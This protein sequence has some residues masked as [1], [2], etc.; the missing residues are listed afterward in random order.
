MTGAL[1]LVGGVVG[2]SVGYAS[3]ASPKGAVAA[4][5][6]SEAEIFQV[7][8]GGPSTQFPAVGV[9]VHVGDT[10]GA[11]YNDETAVNNVPPLVPS[12][13]IDGTSV[14][15]VQ[16]A[17]S[18]A[19][20]AALDA[21]G[22]GLQKFVTKLSY[23]V[24]TNTLPGT[25]TAVM[26]AW[27][28]DQNKPGGDCGTAQW[29]YTVQNKPQLDLTVTKTNDA[30]KDGAFTDT[31]TAKTVGQAVDFKV[32]IANPNQVGVVIDSIKDNWPGMPAGYV[33]S[34]TPNPAG[35]TLA[36]GAST[37]VTFNVPNYGPAVLTSL[38]DTITVN[39]HQQ[40]DTTNTVSKFDSS[41]VNGPPPSSLVLT[42]NKTNDA[43]QD[44]TFSDTETVNSVGQS[45]DFQAILTNTSVVGVTIDSV[46]DTW[47]GMPAGTTITFTPNLVGTTIAAGQSKTVTFSVAN[48]GP[49]TGTTI[50][51]TVTV[52]GHQEGVPSNTITSSDTSNVAGPGTLILGV[53]KTNNADLTGN[54]AK[55]ETAKTAGQD[56]EFQLAIS[57]P[58]GVDLVLSSITDAWP[59]HA[60]GPLPSGSTCA[61]LVGSTLAAGKTTTCKFTEPAY[62][63]D[64]GAPGITNT[65]TVVGSNAAAHS[66]SVRAAATDPNS[67]TVQDTSTVNPPNA[68]PVLGVTIDKTNDANRDS[69][70]SDGETGTAVGQDVTFQLKITNTSAVPVVVSSITDAWP[71]HTEAAVA[72]SSSCGALVGTTLDP[73]QSKTCT[74]AEANY[75]PAAGSN[76]VNTAKVTVTDPNNPGN[77]TTD[78]DTSV[79]TG[80]GTPVLSLGVVKLNDANNDG[81]YTDNETAPS[82]GASVKFQV[83]VTNTSPVAV[84]LTSVTDEWPG[85]PAFSLANSCPSLINRV[86]QPGDTTA[87]NECQ[88]VQANYAPAVGSL[89]VNTVKVN[90][91]QSS[92][93]ANS[94][95][96]NSNTVTGA[97]TTT[98]GTAAQVLPAVITNT[99]PAAPAA[100]PRTGRNSFLLML[101]GG[102]LFL[103]GAVL[104]M[105]TDATAVR[106]VRRAFRY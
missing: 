73:G 30:N 15:I 36:P 6:C 16:S 99:P 83:T 60:D 72:T 96:A 94:V 27:D 77:T 24:P 34:F 9:T 103:A 39:G 88:W 3:A 44:K 102:L 63:P 101:F 47:P 82:P 106:Y 33:P 19:E 89:L 69:S 56:V 104:I 57:N 42:V 48:Y 70:F 93:G 23:T 2:V 81:T 65:V 67:V 76:V 50:T 51:D 86:L 25:H 74:F 18:A 54:F 28:S 61:S 46:G 20:L 64:A 40:G 45:V 98:V 11:F 21:L 66:A 22:K 90:G 87:P 71:G 105:S 38:T 10:I 91:V 53:V 13:T 17:P 8:K 37:T 100:L 85:M 52:T 78:S 4:A 43:N 68:L 14:P 80:P 59:G 31:E 7:G 84:T 92:S 29:T 5:N 32:V 1:L 58:S 49:A 41:T 35:T 75:V 62:A 79:V 12:L 55:V 95:S 97:D 26:T